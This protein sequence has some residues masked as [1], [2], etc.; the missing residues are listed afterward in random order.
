MTK[1]LARLDR[2]GEVEIRDVGPALLSAY[3]DFFDKS[4]FRDFP[5]WQS[6]YC[7]E[8]HRPANVS[9]DDW[10]QRVAE[11]NREKNRKRWRP[12]RGVP[13]IRST[14]TTAAPWHVPP[15]RLRAVPRGG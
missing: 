6:C 12:T 7:M 8:T 4:A 11:K 5:E 15:G 2:I 9:D 1:E 3:L 13:M 14:P 10:D